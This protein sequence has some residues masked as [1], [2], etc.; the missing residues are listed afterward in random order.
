MVAK[1]LLVAALVALV[2]LAPAAAAETITVPFTTPDGGVTSGLYA[3]TVRVTVS[4]TGFS[5][6]SQINDAFYLVASA[7]HDPDYYQLTFDTVPLV[8]FEPAR[9]AYHFIPTGLPAYDPTHVYSFLLDTGV[10]TPSALH[11][12]VSDGAFGDN[13]GAYTVTVGVPEP[14]VWTL[15]VLGFGLIGVPLRRRVRALAV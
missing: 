13:G 6:G 4:G 3:G 2:P 7:T 14:A 11:F 5:L 9:D 8:P 10:T 12:G 15:L 1:K